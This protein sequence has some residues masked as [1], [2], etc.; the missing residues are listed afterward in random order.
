MK[1]N[2][3]QFRPRAESLQAN[4]VYPLN[5]EGNFFHLVSAT[6]SLQI[7][8]ND[9]EYITITQGQGIE[10]QQ[11]FRKLQIKSA[12]AQ[13]VKWVTGFGRFRDNAQ[14]VNVTTSATID[15]AN[16]Y[17]PA[18]DVTVLAGSSA[19]L[20]GSN[21]GRRALTITNPTSNSNTF[22]LGVP[23][24]VG[25][26]KGDILEPGDTITMA[27]TAAI[28]AYNTGATDESLTVNE[29]EQV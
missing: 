3:V 4:V 22:R 21:A 9:G 11:P 26:N 17:T 5:S 27:T 2:S 8:V 18:A 28:D 25:A 19:N 29:L 23:L 14:N 6:S 15:P 1:N 10:T 13:S 16:T 12:A 7:S 24:N 20:I